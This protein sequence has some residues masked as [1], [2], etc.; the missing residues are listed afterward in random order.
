ML[1][2]QRL[3]ARIRAGA[4]RIGFGGASYTEAALVS[5]DGQSLRI[6]DGQLKEVSL[7]ELEEGREYQVT[8]RPFVNNHWIELKI[9]D[10]RPL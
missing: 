9:V 6:Y 5:E 7:S 10:L 3:E 4:R 2:D 1:L 8:F